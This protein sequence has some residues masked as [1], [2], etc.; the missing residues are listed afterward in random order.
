MM[1]FAGRQ[2][3]YPWLA[4]SQICSQADFW[5]HN[6][7]NLDLHCIWRAAAW[8]PQV[9]NWT[10][11]W[12]TSRSHSYWLSA[13]VALNL[14]LPSLFLWKGCAKKMGEKPWWSSG[15]QKRQWE[16]RT[17]VQAGE[18]TWPQYELIHH[19]GKT[20][21]FLGLLGR[22]FSNYG[23]CIYHQQLCP[24][25]ILQTETQDRPPPTVDVHWNLRSN[26]CSILC[27]VHT[28]QRLACLSQPFGLILSLQFAVLQVDIWVVSNVQSDADCEADTLNHICD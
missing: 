17:S 21:H 9:F 15:K 6:D 10:Q 7:V 23:L 25:K 4:S 11:W 26:Y 28:I 13:N 12:C 18:I 14:G 24:C 19:L 2:P 8:L 20:G 1:N 22:T 5:K 16:C 3:Y 27:T